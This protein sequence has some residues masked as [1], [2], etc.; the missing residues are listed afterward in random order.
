MDFDFPAI[1]SFWNDVAPQVN[2]LSDSAKDAFADDL[3]A[4]GDDG[5]V[6]VWSDA[7][8]LKAEVSEGVR[9]VCRAHNVLPQ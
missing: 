5:L 1:S 6:K 7:G 4:L 2:D 9:R 3:R 8:V